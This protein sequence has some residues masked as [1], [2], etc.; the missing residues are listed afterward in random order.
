MSRNPVQEKP[1]C[2]MRKDIH[3]FEATSCFAILQ[4]RL[5][6]KAQI[7]Q[8]NG[9]IQLKDTRSILGE[10]TYPSSP[11]HGKLGDH[12]KLKRPQRGSKHSPLI[13]QFKNTW[14]YASTIPLTSPCRGAEP[15]K[16][17]HLRLISV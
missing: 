17:I 8:Y 1:S 7:C 4:T 11:F 13:V 14:S 5:K 12:P 6:I 3:D 9:W 2:S 10:Y 16:V 15:H